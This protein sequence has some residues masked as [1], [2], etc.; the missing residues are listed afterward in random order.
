[1]LVTLVLPSL[2]PYRDASLVGAGGAVLGGLAL[3]FVWSLQGERRFLAAAGL[4]GVQ[5]LLRLAAVGACAVAGLTAA[6]MMLGYAVLAPGAIALAGA[7]LLLGRPVPVAAEA[8]EEREAEGDV[9]VRR[10]RTFAAA[11]VFAALLLNGDVL[12]LT[13]LGDAQEVAAYAAAWRFG[14]GMLLI[15]TAI[16]SALLPFILT[17]DDAWTETKHLVRLGLLV[18]LGW[19]VLVPFVVV[20]GPLILG[21]V[22]DEAKAPL[23]LLAIAFAIDGF[24]FVLYQIY[25]RVGRESLIL[26]LGVVEFATM[27]LVTVLL[28]DHGALAP[29]WGQL[30]ARVVVVCFGVAPVVLAALGRCDWF[31]EPADAVQAPAAT[32][33]S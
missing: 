3:F 28:R 29:A 6:P 22:G 10:R 26:G 33:T 14:A 5:G 30:V 7:F 13:V 1:M 23:T 9:N 20:L 24:Y 19:L 32:T 21:S 2:A 18:V 25:V 27:A 16:A 11:G 15:N 31:E 8:E 12:L 4:Q 17:A